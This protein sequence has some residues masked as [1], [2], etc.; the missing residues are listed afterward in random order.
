MQFKFLAVISRFAVKACGLAL[1]VA[2]CPTTAFAITATP[3]IDP[4]SMGSALAL[5]TGGFLMLKD[6]RG[7]QSRR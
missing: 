5:F 7:K 1:V 6:W 2:A 4:G 3:E